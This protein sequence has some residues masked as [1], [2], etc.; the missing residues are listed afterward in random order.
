MNVHLR[1]LRQVLAW[2]LLAL[3]LLACW[4]ALLIGCPGDDTQQNSLPQLPTSTSLTLQPIT[5]SLASP[6]FMTAAPNDIGRLFIVEQGG[7]IRIFDVGAGTIL[8]APFLNLAGLITSGG[9]RGLLGMAFDPNYGAN[10]RI[11][12]FYTNTNGD[13]VIARYQR[14]IV[15]PNLA[16]PSTATI[17]QTVP[18]PNFA[19]HN[20]GMLAFGPDGCLYA[21]IGDGGSGGDPNNNGQNSFSQLGK[22]LRLNPDTGGPCNNVIINPFLLGGGAQEVWSLGLRNPWRFTFDRQTGDLYIADV[23]Q[24]AREEI[25]VSLSPNAGR[26]SNYGWRLMEGFACFNPPSNCNPGG[27]TLPVI[28]YPHAS[29]TCSVTGG[30]VYRGTA[31]PSL[32]GT[33]FYADLCNGFVRSF[34]LQ[35]GQVAEQLEW[36]LL[37]PPGNFVTSFAEDA[38]GEMYLMNLSGG[39]WR[40]VPN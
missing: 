40:I 35:N 31:I 34:R 8:A 16:D 6:V 19:N 11:Y 33:Y 14:S 18:H 22:L 21:G 23:G 25:N 20:G 15:N 24:N 38:Q 13:V 3:I 9:E 28:D 4:P 36:P 12:V 17:L 37:S 2:P 32:R 7:T 30:Y 27:L 10:G 39:L 26:Q 1:Q 5:T 29:G